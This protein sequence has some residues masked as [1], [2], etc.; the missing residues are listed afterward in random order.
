VPC[1]T[2]TATYEM[3]MAGANVSTSGHQAQA[4]SRRSYESWR[5][6][7]VLITVEPVNQHGRPGGLYG[8]ARQHERQTATRVMASQPRRAPTNQALL[9]MASPDVPA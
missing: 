9:S 5:H 4:R 1:V 7:S 3:R 8:E 2:A 6:T